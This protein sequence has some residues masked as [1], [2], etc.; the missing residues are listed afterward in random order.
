MLPAGVRWDTLMVAS[1]DD[2]S[3]ADIGI[4]SLGILLFD[5]VVSTHPSNWR[6]MKSVR[7]G[8]PSCSCNVLQSANARWNSAAAAA[9]QNHSWSG[10][11]HWHKI[12]KTTLK[13]FAWIVSLSCCCFS[14]KDFQFVSRCGAESLWGVDLQ[15]W[16]VH[17]W[18][19]RWD[20]QE[21]RTA[22]EELL[23]AGVSCCLMHCVKIL[24]Y[25][26]IKYKSGKWKSPLPFLNFKHKS[27]LHIT[28]W[29]IS[30]RS[31]NWDMQLEF[32]FKAESFQRNVI[33]VEQFVKVAG[34]KWDILYILIILFSLY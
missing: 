12:R 20:R 17:S 21:T 5:H 6:D 22:T 27:C 18:S 7:P 11:A 28:L 24:F 10:R 9:E 15:L 1:A 3:T 31:N 30:L 26:N 8:F 32:F 13:Y 14:C 16:R 2:G 4:F 19:S 23:L 34:I 29:N 25:K 33:Y